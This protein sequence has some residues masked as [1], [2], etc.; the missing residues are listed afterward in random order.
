MIFS[1]VSIDEGLIVVGSVRRAWFW[2]GLA[3]HFDS[4]A[5]RWSSA[6]WPRSRPSPFVDRSFLRLS[7][8]SE[9]GSRGGP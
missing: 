4:A 9:E 6:S 5:S 8:N 2:L 7:C 3:S 1:S